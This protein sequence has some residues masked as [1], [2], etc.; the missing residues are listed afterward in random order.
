MHDFDLA[1][2]LYNLNLIIKKITQSLDNKV[3][4]I[5]TNNKKKLIKNYKKIKIFWGNRLNK[6]L[7]NNLVNLKWVHFGSSGINFE[8]K[9]ELIKKKNTN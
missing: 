5:S 1:L 7:L 6:D 2:K 9:E 8:L 3:V 4:F